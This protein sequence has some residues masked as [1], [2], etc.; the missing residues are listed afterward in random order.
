MSPSRVPLSRRRLLSLLSVGL[1]LANLSTFAVQAANLAD[2]VEKIKPSIV[3]VGT[4]Q[5]P[6][7]PPAPIKG[8]RV[9]GGPR[10]P[11][12]HHPPPP[13]GV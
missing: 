4:L 12:Q 8:P 6:P 7:P 10:R 3:A 9:W 1:L 11:Q 13:K 2:T 5:P